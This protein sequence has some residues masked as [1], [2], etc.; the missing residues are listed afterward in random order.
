MLILVAGEKIHRLA[1]ISSIGTNTMI[2]SCV[3]SFPYISRFICVQVFCFGKVA[4]VRE[5]EERERILGIEQCNIINKSAIIII[6]LLCYGCLKKCRL[7]SLTGAWV[8][9]NSSSRR[10]AT[11]RLL[12]EDALREKHND[13]DWNRQLCR[14][15]TRKNM[16]L[17]AGHV[18]VHS[19]YYH[20]YCPIINNTQCTMCQENVFWSSS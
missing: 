18:G 2:N 20:Y 9:K 4:I 13:Y 11:L 7:T 5:D 16:L 3:Y 10:P 6:I 15:K 19:L 14:R 1:E 17:I 12:E 8:R